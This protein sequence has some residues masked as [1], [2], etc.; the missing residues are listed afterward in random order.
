MHL[1]CELTLLLVRLCVCVRVRVPVRA[2]ALTSVRMDHDATGS[3]N[4]VLE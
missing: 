3:Q 1:N 4:L 2:R